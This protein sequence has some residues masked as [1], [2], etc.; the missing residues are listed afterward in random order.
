MAAVVQVV[1]QRVQR[2]GDAAY[3]AKHEVQEVEH[4]LRRPAVVR[5]AVLDPQQLNL[6]REKTREESAREANG[7]TAGTS[8]AESRAAGATA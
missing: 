2:E 4:L 7:T 8:P 5:H 1:Q 6:R 3:E